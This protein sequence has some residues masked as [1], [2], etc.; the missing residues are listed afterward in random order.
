MRA[1][2]FHG[3]GDIRID[4]IPEPQ[5]RPGTVAID[6]AWCGICGT[7]LHEYLEGPIFIPPTGSPQPVS[8]E[9]APIVMG[10]EFS[11][12]VRA[13]GDGVDD[14]SVG[15]AVVVEPYIIRDEVDAS[16]GQPYQLS[17]DMNFIGLGGRGG[18]LS[19]QIVVQRRWV[20]PVGDVPL[21]QAALIEPLAVGHHAYVRS[22]AG[23][24]DVALVGGAGPIGLLLAAL[25]TA[26]GL[27][28]VV[29]EVSAARKAKA[30]ETGVAAHVL[31]PTEGDV[32]T[33]VRELTGGRGAD[34]AFEC[35][36]VDAVLDTLLDAVRPGG[37]VVNVSIWGHPASVDMQ[38]LVLKEID[39]RGTIAYA[40]DHPATIELVRSG[41]VDLAPFI[42][43]RIALE[44]LVAE[45][46]DALVHRKD[47]Q[48]KILVHP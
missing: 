30:V 7:D 48:V 33:R 22:G 20:H 39:L 25:L 46:L 40:G 17:P 13:L 42:T 12:T 11:G 34:V 31:D 24:G 16:P 35:T 43:A 36:S 26:E 38:K 18:G 37:V 6:V 32:A 44:D 2:R 10:H 41:K 1:A 3:R 14:L 8:G 28:V 19:E 23:A 9:A 45:G 29:T 4:E 5:L 27:T 15:D 47:T 21:D